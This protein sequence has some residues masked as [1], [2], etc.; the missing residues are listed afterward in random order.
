[1]N[2]KNS[3]YI[4]LFFVICL[5]SCG[6]DSNTPPPSND[7]QPTISGSTC[8]ILQGY[9]DAA[10]GFNTLK[11]QGLSDPLYIQEK[12]LTGNSYQFAGSKEQR[13]D[14]MTSM[15]AASEWLP[16]VSISE[17]RCYWIKHTAPLLYTYLKLRIAYIDGNAVGIEY[18]IDST[19]ER[20]DMK[21]ERILTPTRPTKPILTS[22]T[23]AFPASTKPTSTWNIP[24]P[25][26]SKR[27]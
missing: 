23:S 16:S 6:D 24:C 10:Q 13:L 22:Q 26:V 19:E 17:G 7:I 11:P 5:T 8:D 4:F 14:E 18:I 2:A 3:F 12:A 27:F 25:T 20:N 15:P 21:Q 9:E 1:M